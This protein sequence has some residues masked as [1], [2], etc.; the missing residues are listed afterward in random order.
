MTRLDMPRIESPCVQV[1]LVDQAS[2]LCMGCRRSVAEIAAWSTMTPA[3]RRRIMSALAS[4]KAAG[5]EGV[6]A[7]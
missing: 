1:C 6:D 5:N 7:R 3:Q 4:R 2:G